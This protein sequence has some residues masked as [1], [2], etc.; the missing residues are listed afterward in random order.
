MII[1]HNMSAAQAVRNMNINATTQSKTMERLASGQRINRASDDAANLFISEKMR[2]QIRGMNQASRNTQD[3]ISMIQVAE[4]ALNEV[5]AILVKLHENFVK[6]ENDVLTIEDKRVVYQENYQLAK[7]VER[8]AQTTQYG[9]RNILDGSTTDIILQ[10]GANGGQT[11]NL[12]FEDMDALTI[13]FDDADRPASLEECYIEDPTDPDNKILNPLNLSRA[14]R[15]VKEFRVQLGAYQNR[16]E[17]TIRNI[18]SNS[19]NLQA[20]ESRIRDADMA[21]EVLKNTRN[22]IL[23]Q[24]S[25]SMLAQANQQPSQIISLLSA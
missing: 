18:D 20:S 4:G 3:G 23:L 6:E 9:S 2:A 25:Q 11:I 17:H 15:M 1:N 13:F 19:E 21:Q 12:V 7:E 14:K 10:V 8:I 16:L 5:S 24:A 22:N